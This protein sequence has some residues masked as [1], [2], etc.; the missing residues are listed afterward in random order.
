MQ[1]F[2]RL[3]LEAVRSESG[4]D[5]VAVLLSGGVD[6]TCVLLACLDAGF[7]VHAYT[8]YLKGHE[9]Q[10]VRA[11]RR[12]CGDLG[13]GL[14]ES[15]VPYSID[16]LVADTRR[17][18]REFGTTRKTAV[19][20][21]H[22]FL[23][24]VPDVKERDVFSGLYADDL[25]GTSR[26]GNQEGHSGEARFRAYR[27]RQLTQQDYSCVYIKKCFERAGKSLHM[28][29][30]SSGVSEYLL[31]LS[32]DDMNRP[33]PKALAVRAYAEHFSKH[34]WYRKNSNLQVNSGIREYHDLLLRTELNTR[35]LKSVTGIYND[36]ANGRV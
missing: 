23:Y 5:E 12:I 2:R 33:K 25:W 34:D 24:V 21:I 18:V 27:Q 15:V 4:S 16:S 8:F 17:I 10:D 22:P 28:P 35:G 31:S 32:W 6:S 9:S 11:S 7:E 14:T 20:C 30:V 29:F 3:M 1:D 26:K 36:I 19:Q 13:I